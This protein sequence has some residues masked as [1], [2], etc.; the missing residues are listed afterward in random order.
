MIIR[1][2]CHRVSNQLLSINTT[3][4]FEWN[5]STIIWETDDG[6]V[7]HKIEFMKVS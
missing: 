4:K 3:C 5:I 7:C 6:D 1:G 2:T